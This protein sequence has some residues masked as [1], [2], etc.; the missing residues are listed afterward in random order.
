L[1]NNVV[2]SINDFC[3]W[4]GLRDFL[5]GFEQPI[6]TDALFTA[7]PIRTIFRLYSETHARFD[8]LTTLP[9][10]GQVVSIPDLVDYDE[11]RGG[12]FYQEWL[13]PQGC[14]DAA[15]RCARAIE[16][17]LRGSAH[18]AFGRAHDRRRKCGG[19]SR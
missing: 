3:R 17:K 2:V 7:V 18:R 4:P 1:W 13:R 15:K 9:P 10:L 19:V 5:E 14:V 12:R 16:P 6:R 8:P 11:Y